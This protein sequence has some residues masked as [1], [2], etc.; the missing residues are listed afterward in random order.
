M[1]C[2]GLI[3]GTRAIN[4]GSVTVS[5]TI[6]GTNF[7]AILAPVGGNAPLPGGVTGGLFSC[8]TLLVKGVDLMTLLANNPAQT[9]PAGVAGQPEVQEQTRATGAQGAPSNSSQTINTA[10]LTVQSLIV[11]EKTHQQQA[12]HQ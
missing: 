8:T 2:G 7:T 12:I 1:S 3:A 10:P 11:N 4:G 9:G 5:D 6:Q